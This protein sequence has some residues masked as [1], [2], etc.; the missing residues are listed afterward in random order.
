MDFSFSEDQ[1]QVAEYIDILKK[2]DF[3]DVEGYLLYIKA[4]DVISVPPGKVSKGK[5]KDESQLGLG[6]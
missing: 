4:G 6:F 3:S 1:K 5:K 2:M